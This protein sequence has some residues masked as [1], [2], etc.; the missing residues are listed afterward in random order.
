V[1]AFYKMTERVGPRYTREFFVE[2]G[3]P[4]FP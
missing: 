2:N 4:L 3:R 1:Q